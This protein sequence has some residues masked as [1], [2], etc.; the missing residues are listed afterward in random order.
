MKK[1][2][3]CLSAFIG[4]DNLGD[5]AIFYQI[6]SDLQKGFFINILSVNPDKTRNLIKDLNKENFNIYRANKISQIFKAIKNSDVFICGGG[7]LIQDQ[8]SVYNLLYHLSKSVLAK[9]LKKKIMFY[10]I[11]VGP[12]RFRLNKILINKIMNYSDIITVR[13]YESKRLLEIIGVKNNLIILTADPAINLKSI[14][15]KEVYKIFKNNGVNTDKPIMTICLRHWFDTYSFIPVRL[16]KKLG[17]QTKKDIMRYNTFIEK[18]SK[19]VSYCRDE[20]NFQIIFLPFWL[21]R[22]NKVH[23]DILSRI[24]N[25]DKIFLLN[26]EFTPSEAKGI[27]SGSDF[28][29]G[30]R[31]HSVILALSENVPFIA[32]SYSS[33]VNNYLRNFFENDKLK[34]VSVNPEKFAV[35]ELI[36]KINYGLKNRLTRTKEFRI[37]LLN[38]MKN[39]KENLN[40]LNRRVIKSK[41][42]L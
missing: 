8:T 31:L 16:V 4:S 28:V 24:K 1:T 2:K 27:I 3:I 35:N 26:K 20:L 25:K 14:S 37:K 5:E 11:G 7:G 29:L 23:E 40:L 15:K 33:K 22:D 32:L 6:V 12:I 39:E 41:I 42:A 10:G 36:E 19:V 38:N 30:M 13:D 18:I 9:I 34:K 17:L 21:D